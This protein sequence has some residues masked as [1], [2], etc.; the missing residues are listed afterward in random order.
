LLPLL[1]VGVERAAGR[2]FLF[3]S[4]NEL[5]L[6]HLDVNQKALLAASVRPAAARHHALPLPG[7][8]AKILA[9]KAT[10]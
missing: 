5:V 4:I 2:D 9:A 7:L 10:R 8:E 1:G 6:Q 3:E